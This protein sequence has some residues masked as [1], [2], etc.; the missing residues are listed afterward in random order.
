[1]RRFE[2]EDRAVLPPDFAGFAA[3]LGLYAECEGEAALIGCVME[4]A[5]LECVRYLSAHQELWAE[6]LTR[7]RYADLVRFREGVRVGRGARA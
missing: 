3:E 2:A 6:L 7:A 1:M 4:Y 5:P